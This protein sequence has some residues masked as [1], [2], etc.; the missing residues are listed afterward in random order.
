M[1][2]VIEGKEGILL[3]YEIYHPTIFII[4][5]ENLNIEDLDEYWFEDRKLYLHN[6]MKVSYIILKTYIYALI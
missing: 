3:F 6:I 2:Y 4:D 1:E 5:D